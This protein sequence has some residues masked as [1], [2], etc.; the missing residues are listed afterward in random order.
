M[1]WLLKVF[2]LFITSHFFF[3]SR[4]PPPAVL[5]S[6]TRSPPCTH[7]LRSTESAWCSGSCCPAPG[8]DCRPTS[9]SNHCYSDDWPLSVTTWRSWSRVSSGGN[10]S[11]PGRLA[12]DWPW[13]S[14]RHRRLAVVD[15]RWD[16]A[17]TGRSGASVLWSP[18]CYPT[19]HHL[20]PYNSSW[21]FIG[22]PNLGEWSFVV[23]GIVVTCIITVCGMIS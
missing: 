3:T 12:W 11:R 8:Y 10:L 7:C 19:I 20:R 4:C 6:V 21:S 16:T 15:S 1:S 17:Y 22:A 14:Q 5:P 18:S 23:A 2:Y 9:C 13:A